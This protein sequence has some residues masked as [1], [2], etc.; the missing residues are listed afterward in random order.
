MIHT[1]FK[2]YIYKKETT[3]ARGTVTLVLC[4][5]NDVKSVASAQAAMLCA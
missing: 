3:A 4:Y 2:H 5:K 1:V